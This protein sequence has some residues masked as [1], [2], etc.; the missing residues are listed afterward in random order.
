M[1]RE[2][3]RNRSP[4][5]AI[6]FI[7]GLLAISAGVFVAFTYVQRTSAE[8]RRQKSAANLIEIHRLLMADF[9]KTKRF[10]ETEHE[11]AQVFKGQEKILIH[12]AWPEAAHYALV[13]DV[14]P[15]TD[16]PGTMLVYEAIPDSKQKFG[17]Q[18][19]D[20]EGAVTL[21]TPDQ[22]KQPFIGQ[23]NRKRNSIILTTGL[24]SK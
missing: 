21:R 18:S 4:K 17:I 22:F 23:A 6:L 1:N 9:K 3:T 12:P 2:V 16:P 20:L 19:V 7:A 5:F 11:A 10:P 15:E 24:E 13:T 14:N 8:E